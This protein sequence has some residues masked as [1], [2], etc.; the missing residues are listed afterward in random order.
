[1]NKISK[2]DWAMSII[3]SV[4]LVFITIPY[5]LK[6]MVIRQDIDNT[7][8]ASVPI[9]TESDPVENYEKFN[10]ILKKNKIKVSSKSADISDNLLKVD[11][12][13]EADVF[14]ICLLTFDLQKD[15]SEVYVDSADIN[16]DKSTNISYIIR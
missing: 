14:E 12:S 2:K 11:L 1:M 5:T 8:A 3:L 10:Q 13:C 16:K 7:K 4:N 9:K 15:L 6:N